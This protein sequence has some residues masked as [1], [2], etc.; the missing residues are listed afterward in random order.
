[1][2]N[3]S[4]FGFALLPNLWIIHFTL[5]HCFEFVIATV[6]WD[7]SFNCRRYGT[8]QDNPGEIYK[9][10]GTDSPGFINFCRDSLHSHFA[11]HI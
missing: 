3:F 11:L 5:T 8:W 4:S 7:Y 9:D 1:M 6:S 2:M 10:A